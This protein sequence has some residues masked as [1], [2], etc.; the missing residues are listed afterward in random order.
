MTAIFA[1]ALALLFVA[2][3]VRGTMTPAERKAFYGAKIVARYRAE[4]LPPEYGLATADWESAHTFDPNTTN[5][6]DP[7]TARG[8]FA[9]LPSTAKALGFNPDVVQ[10][11]FATSL[12]CHIAVVNDNLRRIGRV[13]I[14]ELASYYNSGKPIAR[15]P[16][17]TTSVYVPAILRLSATYKAEIAAGKYDSNV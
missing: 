6:N 4:G 5:P 7:G 2:A 3:A 14:A 10:A 16:N 12:D 17:S 13:D 1:A 11:D 8:M 15:A 9:I